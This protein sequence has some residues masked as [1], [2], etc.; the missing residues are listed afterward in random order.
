MGHPAGSPRLATGS[1]HQHSEF[2]D[3]A[4]SAHS[5]ANYVAV[6]AKQAIFGLEV[7]AVV[8]VQ[9]IAIL[10][11]LGADPLIVSKYEVNTSRARQHGTGDGANGK[12]FGALLFFPAEIDTRL[13]TDRDA[14]N[15]LTLR[16]HDPNR[17]VLR[18]AHRVRPVR[19]KQQR[20]QA[21]NTGEGHRLL[22]IRN[23]TC[24]PGIEP[25]MNFFMSDI[26]SPWSRR[27]VLRG[28]HKHGAAPR[29]HS[30]PN[31]LVVAP[32]PSFYGDVQ[33]GD[34]SA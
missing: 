30:T 5:I 28:L 31:S 18:R 10:I 14:K 8:K 9:A 29:A 26:P 16:R 20:N 13:R 22:V 4:R 17:P 12:T 23:K 11:E 34:P 3:L 6:G 19:G 1:G 2:V 33:Y 27:T 32:S 25:S 15:Y 24:Q 7:E 21:K